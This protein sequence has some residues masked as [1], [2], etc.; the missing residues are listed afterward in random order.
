MMIN[1]V[2][3]FTNNC[4][5]ANDPC[6]VT[7]ILDSCHV[8]ASITAHLSV[9]VQGC[10][11]FE[12]IKSLLSFR[13]LIDPLSFSIFSLLHSLF[14]TLIGAPRYEYQSE[15]TSGERGAGAESSVGETRDRDG[16]GCSP[17]GT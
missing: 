15:T 14:Q 3:S 7:A 12:N 1:D 4:R 13:L 16:Y 6:I 9:K 10:L 8:V 17:G 2:I 5:A 11:F